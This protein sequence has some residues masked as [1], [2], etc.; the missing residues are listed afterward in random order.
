[1]FQETKEV[2]IYIDNAVHAYNIEG[3]EMWVHMI[4]LMPCKT[5]S[6][7]EVFTVSPRW[8]TLE[9]NSMC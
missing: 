8:V 9:P 6:F 5:R 7:T 4:Y 3:R 2:I 1:M